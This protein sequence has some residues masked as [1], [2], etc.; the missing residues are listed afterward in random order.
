MKFTKQEIKIAGSIL[1]AVVL[2]GGMFALAGQ[3]LGADKTPFFAWWITLLLLGFSFYPLTSCIFKRFTDGGYLFS[4]TIAL[5]MSGW[6]MWVLSSL[7]ILKFTRTACIVLVILCAVA[8]YVLAY[9]IRKRRKEQG[10]QLSNPVKLL[11]DRLP[12]LSAVKP[13]W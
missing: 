1:A 7:H 2:F 9:I 13:V 11:A 12:Y 4:K 3:L 6:L 5:A 10:V 8:N